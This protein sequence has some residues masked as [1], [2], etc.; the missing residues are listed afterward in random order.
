MRRNVGFLRYWTVSNIPL[1][2]LAAP[3]LCM[4]FYSSWIALTGRA[5]AMSS[6]VTKIEKTQSTSVARSALR[7]DSILIRLA[8]VEIALATLAFTSFHVQ[9]INR[10]SS[11]YPVW[12]LI[13]A[14][15]V[16]DGKRQAKWMFRWII[17]YALIQAVL[18]TAFLPPA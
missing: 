17:M 13:L 18:F 15:D 16:L 11:G 8:L 14:R 9:I 6:T 2:L 10:I 5:N 3:M 7:T 4:M 12:Y 1:F